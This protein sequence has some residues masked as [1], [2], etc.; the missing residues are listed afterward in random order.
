MKQGLHANVPLAEYLADPCE[1]PSLS[2]GIAH[3]L[4]S[5][6]PLHAKWQH[7]R[8]STAYR[9]KEDTKFDIGTAAHSLLLEG[10]DKVA[11]VQADDWRTK[12]AQQQRTEARNNGMT[13][14]LEK[15]YQA[16]KA[17]VEEAER[18]LRDCELAA[19]LRDAQAELTGIVKRGN[20]WLR[21]RPDKLSA[22][23]CVMVNY[24]TCE[25]A[26]PEI[27]SRQIPR[28]G[29]DLSAAFYELCMAELGHK[30]EEVFLAQETTPPYAC[31]LVGLDSATREIARG[32]VDLALKLWEKCI[33]SDRWPAYSSKIQ[34]A[35]PSTWEMSAH[36]ERLLTLDERLELAGQA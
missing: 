17:M 21:F 28:L 1:A 22:D 11:V 6:S 25:N 30:S 19:A 26:N 27:F 8:L 35:T 23:R 34:Y 32:K 9:T 12:A 4:I 7:P 3:I 33:G 24:K 16:V 5:Q 2:A 36:E 18:Y 29:Y 14:L 15:H 20:L 31:S 13:P 10:L